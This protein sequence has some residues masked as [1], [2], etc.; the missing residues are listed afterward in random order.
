MALGNISGIAYVVPD[1]P[2]H[3]DVLPEDTKGIAASIAARLREWGLRLNERVDTLASRVDAMAVATGVAPGSPEDGVVAGLVLDTASNTRGALN[4]VV[5]SILDPA[6]EALPETGALRVEDFGAVC[7]GVTD[8]TAALTAGLAE[9][10]RLGL[11]LHLPANNRIAVSGTLRPPSGAT[12][13]GNGTTLE[14]A[15]P[16]GAGSWLVILSDTTGVTL[17]DVTLKFSAGTASFT[18]QRGLAALRAR[19]LTLDRVS[20]WS[21]SDTAASASINALGLLLQDC[22]GLRLDRISMDGWSNAIRLRNLNDVDITSLGVYR[23]RLGLWVSDCKRVRVR[24]GRIWG[25]NFKFAQDSGHN[26]I[27]VDADVN[28]GTD[29]ILF[30]DVTVEDSGATGFRL[31]GASEMY[32]IDFVR[33]RAIRAGSNGFKTLGGTVESRTWH[34]FVSF[35]DCY[36]EDCGLGGG[37]NTAAIAVH[38]STDV[39]ITNLT[40]RAKGARADGYSS[41]EAV[42]IAGSH[43][44]T[45][46]N[47]SVTNPEYAGIYLN[48]ALGEYSD[49]TVDGARIATGGA[50]TPLVISR[51]NITVRRVVMRNVRVNHS[52]T[53]YVISTAKS[54][55]STLIGGIRVE[56]ELMNSSAITQICTGTGRPDITADL[57]GP[58]PSDLSYTGFADGSR[59]WAADGRLGLRQSGTWRWL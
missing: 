46:L 24:G 31:G 12:L 16:T 56:L 37:T 44:V 42:S 30:E 15:T 53:G 20:L 55:T 4:G 57:R 9:S 13:E 25:K 29:T 7:D 40:V 43:R 32:H 26:G 36:V 18:D 48:S 54:D 58:V 17:R 2:G 49:I 14:W 59:W 11:P 27:L 23:Y 19:N 33:C 35:T 5:Q 45:V 28:G 38:L 52:G 22:V 10:A 47:V 3:P 8:D 41:R 51:S 39:T 6:L 34:R 1:D 21:V 50:A